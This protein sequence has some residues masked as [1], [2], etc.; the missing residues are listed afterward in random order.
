MLL[1]FSFLCCCLLL[2]LLLRGG[3]FSA[4][5][6][7]LSK[8]PYDYTKNASY[9][10]RKTQF[11]ML[12]PKDADIVF[13]GDSI[14][15]RF[16]WDEFFT[17]Y[18]IANRGIDSD[19]SAGLLNRLDTVIS[20][21]PEKIFLMIGINDIQQHISTETTIK[22]YSLII[23]RLRENLPGCEIY[24]QSVL[25][26]NSSTGIDNCLVQELN[27]SLSDLAND[28]GVTY[29]DIYSY[30]TDSQNNFNYTVD[31]VHPTGE[32]YQIWMDILKEYID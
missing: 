9:V 25:P 26:V 3:Y 22:N 31:G 5:Q 6:T 1:C 24:I 32:G 7:S 18:T 2:F 29:I 8:E 16:E 21:N 4:L 10:Q 23:D 15:A 27:I 19:I 11:E 28:K 14:T 30:M 13:A 20:Q 17:D 12:P